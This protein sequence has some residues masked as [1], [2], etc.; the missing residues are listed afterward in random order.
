MA[1]NEEYLTDAAANSEYTVE[2]LSS[3]SADLERAIQSKLGKHFERCHL[4]G[5]RNYWLKELRSESPGAWLA[6]TAHELADEMREAGIEFDYDQLK[7]VADVHRE[8]FQR[9]GVTLKVPGPVAR[10]K[11]SSVHYPIYVEFPPGWYQGESL[12]F[13]RF[14]EMV[15]RYEMSPAE[16]LDIWAVELMRQS[17]HDWAAK[18]GVQAEAVRKNIR[19]ARE[20]RQDDE[21]G[22]THERANIR[23]APIEDIPADGPHDAEE[24]VFYQPTEEIADGW[25]E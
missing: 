15:S 18:R 7:L 25:S 1:L 4:Q 12:T 17:A 14:H 16:A 21:L 8:R 22:A 23:V 20:K 11:K 3:T 5:G 13:Q 10:S 2:E 19:Q 9:N 6:F 24:D